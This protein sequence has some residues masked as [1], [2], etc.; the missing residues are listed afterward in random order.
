[1]QKPSVGRIVHY[2]EPANRDA[3][4]YEPNAAIIVEVY[5]EGT[6]GLYVFP[7][8]FFP[9]DDKDHTKP[10]YKQHIHYSE[11]PKPGH[12]SWPPRV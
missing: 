9:P 6:V 5:P 3:A 12:W 2:Y 11:N 8:L 7:P 1:M 10:A 4:D